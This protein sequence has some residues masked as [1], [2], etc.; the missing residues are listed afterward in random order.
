MQRDLILTINPGSTSTKIGIFKGRELIIEETLRHSA[1][2]LSQFQTMFAQ[3]DFRYQTVRSCLDQHGINDEK[4]LAVVGRGGMLKP[5]PG[6][7]YLVNDLMKK[8]LREGYSGQHASNLGGL[9]ADTIASKAGVS[10]YIVDPT[11]VDELEPL[12]RYSGIPEIKRR[13]VQ[14]TL[15]QKMVAHQCATDL[16]KTYETANFVIAHLGGGISVC[17]HRAGKIIDSNNALDGDGPFSPERAG[18]LPVGDVIRLAYSGRFTETELRK[19]FVGKGGLVA[20]LGSNDGREIEEKIQKNDMVAKEA[21]EAMGYQIAKEIGAAA[22]VLNGEID[23]II[24]TGG[25]AY[26]KFLTEFIVSKIGFLGK[27]ILYPG[28]DELLALAEGALRVINGLEKVME[29]V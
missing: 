4:L 20:Y 18:G 15:N 8:H 27:I 13:S 10:A 5:L 25:L 7:T 19:H 29:Y 17:A 26:S 16:G 22:V 12:A 9:L 14:H 21:F 28:E 24:L 6:G 2:E 3:F 23:A 11:V 1:D